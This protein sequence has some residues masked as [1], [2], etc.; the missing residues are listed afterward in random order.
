MMRS[1]RIDPGD[2]ASQDLL[3]ITGESMLTWRK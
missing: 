2:G 1:S 3:E